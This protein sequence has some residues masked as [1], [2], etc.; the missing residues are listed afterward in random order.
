MVQKA[1][2]G[3]IHFFC[4]TNQP[5]GW[6]NYERKWPNVAEF[7]LGIGYSEEDQRRRAEEYRD[8][9]NRTIPAQPPIGA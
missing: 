7:P 3:R 5:E 6:D 8:Y 4:V 9:M 2:S 1:F